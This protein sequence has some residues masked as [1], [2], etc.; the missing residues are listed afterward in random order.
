MEIWGM[1]PEGYL[2][3]ELPRMHPQVVVRVLD[4]R[5]TPA[6][7][8][9]TVDVDMEKRTVSLVWRAHLVVQG[10][11]DAVHWIKVQV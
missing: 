6:V 4:R 2:R 9:D 7:A 3:F 1:T 5:E 10:Q 11:V 8:C